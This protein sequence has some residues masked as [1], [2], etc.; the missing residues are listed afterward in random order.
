M[1]AKQ[2][3]DRRAGDVVPREWTFGDVECY[4]TVRMRLATF[5]LTLTIASLAACS[6][7]NETAA[8]PSGSEITAAESEAAGA[9]SPSVGTS[10]SPSEEERDQPEYPYKGYPKVIPRSEVPSIMRSYADFDTVVAVAPGV[11]TQDV[12][13]VK[14]LEAAHTGAYFGYCAAV[15]KA[16]KKLEADTGY[17]CW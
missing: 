4:T 7:G 13:G 6:N 15:E 12:P 17:T 16:I 3:V 9:P 1:G 14:P 2:S 8:Q 11:Y 10:P 5:A